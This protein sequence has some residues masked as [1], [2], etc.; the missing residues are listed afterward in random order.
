MQSATALRLEVDLRPER[1]EHVGRAAAAVAERLPCLATRQPAPA[2]ISAAAVDT[3][4]VGRPP[5]VPA[6]STRPS[7]ASTGTA[8]SRMARASPVISCTVSPF[9][10]SAIRKAAVWASEASPAMISCSTR[11]RLVR[12]QALAAGHP[13]D[14]LG[15][16]PGWSSEE[17][18]EELPCPAR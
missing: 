2:A 1:L 3:L 13:V 8:S 14:G 5:P 9:V 18:A 11:G 6:V 16:G 4:K 7:P 15:R 10:R 12:G 17:V